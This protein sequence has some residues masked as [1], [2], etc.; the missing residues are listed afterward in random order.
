MWN[1]TEWGNEVIGMLSNPIKV[2]L[3]EGTKDTEGR[4]ITDGRGT[5]IQLRNV[6]LVRNLPVPLHISAKADMSVA[7]TGAFNSD[8]GTKF[9][10]ESFPERYWDHP[11]WTPNGTYYLG[12]SGSPKDEKYTE[13]MSLV[14][15]YSK[16]MEEGDRQAA[17]DEPLFKKPR[18]DWRNYRG[19]RR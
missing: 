13:N 4:E 8:Q 5:E 16:I 18:L 9:K 7:N 10:K 6:L 11:Y 19:D 12:L 1:G 2:A 14:A 15:E 17:E 3:T